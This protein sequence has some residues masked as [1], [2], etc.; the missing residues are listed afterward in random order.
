MANLLRNSDNLIDKPY[1]Y[2]VWFYGEYNSTLKELEKEF[3]DRLLTVKGLPPNIDDYIDT[4]KRGCHVYDDLMIQASSSK[5]ITELCAYKT[6]HCNIS[7]I[8]LFQN[9]FHN[10]K[11]RL[12]LYRCSHYI[13]LFDNTLDKSQ[14]HHL[15]QKI[16]PGKHRLFLKIFDKATSVPHG[17][18]FIDGRQTTP[19]EARFR[20]DMFQGYQKVFIPE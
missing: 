6:Q 1:D 2:I 4:S 19:K 7:W 17:Y 9:I 10:G 15:G 20:T 11:E 12:N 14:I 13:C 8:F 3:G 5:N 18:L 16:L